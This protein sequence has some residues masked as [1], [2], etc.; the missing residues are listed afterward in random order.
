MLTAVVLSGTR[1]DITATLLV[2]LSVT[3]LV[4]LAAG[5]PQRQHSQPG[6]DRWYAAEIGPLQRN[7]DNDPAARLSAPGTVRRLPVGDA[8]VITEHPDELPTLSDIVGHRMAA[9]QLDDIVGPTLRAGRRPYLRPWGG[10]ILHGAPATDASLLARAIAGEHQVPLLTVQAARLARSP[11]DSAVKST[12]STARAAA[13]CVL[14]VTDLDALVAHG[15]PALQRVASDL[16]TQLRSLLPSDRLAVLGVA[17]KLHALPRSLCD[18]GGFDRAVTVGALTASERARIIQREILLHAA[19][20]DDDLQAATDLTDGLSASQLRAVIA[21]AVRS[22]RAR[23]AVPGGPLM[24]SVRDLREGTVEADG[25]PAVVPLAWGSDVVSSLH[26]F[27]AQLDDG[28]AIPALALLGAAGNGKTAAARWVAHR[29]GR[30]VVWIAGAELGPM[31][32]RD[33]AAVVAG[34]VERTPVLVVIDDIAA[35]PLSPAG[36]GGNVSRA[37]ERLLSTV[38]AGLLVT[39]RT[40]WNLPGA[41]HLND[42][43]A[44]CW[45]PHPTY[46]ERLAL[47]QRVMP[48]ADGAALAARLHGATRR[49][50]VAAARNAGA[51]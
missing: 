40:Q 20:L 12:F 25:R 26:R 15:S 35:L 6:A 28:R 49:D 45:I 27:V 11:L 3:V 21:G 5:T 51:P 13:P 41:H 29:C 23:L 36:A 30:W 37:I 22:V 31:T 48:R 1:I 47:I 42:R 46:H 33:V 38:G 19:T 39:S 17:A 14:V 24:V 4:L 10:V 50:V 9:A 2:V 8:L 7:G 16:L 44:S 32:P 18:S 43:I 34:V